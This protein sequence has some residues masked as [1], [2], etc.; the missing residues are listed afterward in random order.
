[1]KRMLLC[2]LLASARAGAEALEEYDFKAALLYNFALQT[3]WP[4]PPDDA[5][6]L[7]V[8]GQNPFGNALAKLAQ[9]KVK[10]LP[11]RVEFPAA[12]GEARACQI[13]YARAPRD[14]MRELAAALRGAPV[15]TVADQPDASSENMMIS[16]NMQNNKVVFDINH[17]LTERSRLYLSSRLLRLARSVQ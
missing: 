3:E 17:A 2:T 14:R 11:V 9:K 8:F 12:V 15:L 16:L 10:G 5:F 13:V 6:R 7:C 4:D 1:M